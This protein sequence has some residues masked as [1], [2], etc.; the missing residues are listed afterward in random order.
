MQELQKLVD[1]TLLAFKHHFGHP[2]ELAVVAPGRTNLIGEHT[3]YNDGH[4]LPIAID[5]YSCAAVSNR[6]DKR[7]RLFTKNLQ[8]SFE[9]DLDDLPEHRPIWVSYIMGVLAE[10]ES[11]QGTIS[12]KDIVVFG[13]V[14]IG[15]GISS[16]A[17]LEVSVATAVE[18]AEQ[19]EI[20]DGEIVNICRRADHNFVG[21]NSGP[22]DQFA[23][24]ACKSGHAGLLDCRSL[25]MVNYPLSD[26]VEYISLFSGIPRSLAA[27]AYNQ[28]QQ[29]CQSAVKLLQRE[30]PEVKAL[31]DATPEM[32][33]SI[34]K[35]LGDTA[36]RRAR[37][38]VTEEKRVFNIIKAFEKSDLESVGGILR[39]GHF[40]L[41]NDY[42]VSLPVLDEMIEW[43]YRQKGIIGARLTGAGFGGSLVC[44]AKRNVL[45][46]EEFAAEFNAKFRGKTEKKPEMWRLHSVD[47]ARYQPTFKP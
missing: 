23:S 13:N 47:G 4:V 1:S 27:S 45:E 2:A 5:R 16:S 20:D 33:E 12:G 41:S 24:R 18:R 46:F 15:S 31:R 25:E 9:F 32:I 6:K 7:V 29:S 17:A 10:L 34:K 14:P 35:D 21:I 37:H 8:K 11:S 28:R 40:S 36:Y 44:L 38:V 19:W 3:D 30:F 22:M 39:E 43:L 26:D 42:E